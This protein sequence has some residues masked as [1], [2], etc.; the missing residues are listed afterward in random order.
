[1][2]RLKRYLPF[3]NFIIEKRPELREKFI[4][5]KTSITTELRVSIQVIKNSEN[6][7]L[8]HYNNLKEVFAIPEEIK[9]LFEITQYDLSSDDDSDVEIIEDNTLDEACTLNKPDAVALNQKENVNIGAKGADAVS[10][11]KC[12]LQNEKVTACQPEEPS[13]VPPKQ[14]NFN[15]GAECSGTILNDKCLP[16]KDVINKNNDKVTACR[17]EE[18]CDVALKKQKNFNVGAD[19]SGAISKDKCLPENIVINKNNK[20]LTV[21]CRPEESCEV[22]PKQ[23]KKT[24]VKCTGAKSKEKCFPHE[25]N[26][27][28]VYQQ[29]TLHVGTESVDCTSKETPVSQNEEGTVTVSRPKDSCEKGPLM[30][31]DKLNTAVEHVSDLLKKKCFPENKMLNKENETFNETSSD[32]PKT[33]DNEP[34]CVEMN[35]V[36]SVLA[37]KNSIGIETIVSK[38]DVNTKKHDSDTFANNSSLSNIRADENLKE[39]NLVNLK[40]YFTKLS[41]TISIGQEEINN[42]CLAFKKSNVPKIN[43]RDPRINKLYEKT[44]EKLVKDNILNKVQQT[45]VP[46]EDTPE[47]PTKTNK[48][49]SGNKANSEATKKK[50]SKKSEKNISLRELLSLECTFKGFNDNNYLQARSRKRRSSICARS[51]IA[52]QIGNIETENINNNSN[53]DLSELSSFNQIPPKRRKTVD[54][55]ENKSDTSEELSKKGQEKESLLMKMTSRSFAEEV[56]KNT[57]INF[58]VANTDINMTEKNTRTCVLCKSNAH[59]LTNHFIR[60]HKAESYT[61]RLTVEEINDLKSP[62][63]LS[64]RS[65][66]LVNNKFRMPCIFCYKYITSTRLYDHLS[67]HTGEYAYQ[68]SVCKMQKPYRNEVESHQQSAKNC[69]N[70]RVG[71]LYRYPKNQLVIHMYGCKICNFVQ[72]NEAN[73]LRHLRVHH[74]V[75]ESNGNINQNVSKY[76]LAVIKLE[77]E[78]IQVHNE[79]CGDVMESGEEDL[80]MIFEDTKENILLLDQVNDLPRENTCLQENNLDQQC[81]S[82]DTN[83]DEM[84]S[85]STNDSLSNLY[86]AKYRIYKYQDYFG[87]Y[88]CVN[89][90]CFFSTDLREEMLNHINDHIPSINQENGFECYYCSNH[91]H[92]SSINALTDHISI[93]HIF[94]R[95]QCPKCSYR[96]Y[97]PGS[98][99]IHYQKI[100]GDNENVTVYECYGKVIPVINRKP[101]MINAMMNNV[102]KLACSHCEMSFYAVSYLEQHLLTV[103]SKESKCNDYPMYAC[104]YCG[105]NFSNINHIRDHIAL[106]HPDELVYA[107]ERILLAGSMDDLL[108][109]LKMSDISLPLSSEN[110]IVKK[111]ENKVDNQISDKSDTNKSE[112]MDLLENIKPSK[113]D[114]EKIHIDMIRPLLWKITSKSGVPPDRIFCCSKCSGIFLTYHRLH[115][116]LIK[117]HSSC[118]MLCPHCMVKTELDFT[119][120]KDCEKHLEQHI[121]H[122][123]LCFHC[124]YTC[125]NESDLRSHAMMVHEAENNEILEE[126]PLN[127]VFSFKIY[128]KKELST[129]R[130]DF[131]IEL[132]KMLEV[133]LKAKQT[134]IPTKWILSANNQFI[135]NFPK[136]CYTEK[137]LKVCFFKNCPFK[138]EDTDELFKHINATHQFTKALHC[139]KCVTNITSNGGWEEFEEHF[140]CHFSKLYVCCLCNYYNYDRQCVITHIKTEHSQRDT[141]LITLI[142][143]KNNTHMGITIV[144]G[145]NKLNVSSFSGCFVENCDEPNLIPNKFVTH[146]SQSHNIQLQYFCEICNE[147]FQCFDASEIHFKSKHM[148]D[149]FAVQLELSTYNNIDLVSGN[150]FNLKINSNETLNLANTLALSKVKEEV[151]DAEINNLLTQLDANENKKNPIKCIDINKLLSN[152]S[153]GCP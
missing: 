38:H 53:E 83:N 8:F 60:N 95:F 32:N 134:T 148:S 141:I 90:E 20:K 112:K 81:M 47:N 116:H 137:S 152:E 135:E 111:Q 102:Q 101:Y 143:S 55:I 4:V 80:D 15:V 73:V 146:L 149:Q 35:Q 22:V 3:I 93:K 27:V 61:S 11:D 138:T 92:L 16:K 18:A 13:E 124:G 72:L 87:L 127:T 12:H 115:C 140:K 21:V 139:S 145:K 6:V 79:A 86:L 98:V 43:I 49:T 34:F 45:C 113:E 71:I 105:V 36:D 121:M 130:L 136:Y 153:K 19:V 77:D 144:L 110:I 5:I 69:R 123:W 68:C 128:V 33:S 114:I 58:E 109:N 129:N 10:K 97:S 54:S 119:Q 107:C 147:Y 62:L 50:H 125:K 108:K 94:S 132:K 117:N 122:L 52:L 85:S 103:H 78:N 63:T 46:S 14:D 48:H 30:Q 89:S 26:K 57:N 104:I 126:L 42:F 1:M 9:Q 120:S 96:S 37:K 28:T 56:P 31:Q 23:Q 24:E 51:A 76:I 131:L 67:T 84:A 40:N 118:I 64:E 82:E 88:K 151:I 150:P 25:P 66:K 70:S 74:Q 59:N 65:Y 7:F 99:L 2:K 142:R 29:E 91:K 44:S 39:M 106:E 133:H 17:P 41:N 75:T 100:H